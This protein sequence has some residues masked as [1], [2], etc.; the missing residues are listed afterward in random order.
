MIMMRIII[1][2]FSLFIFCCLY[3][4]SSTEFPN[5]FI[6]NTERVSIE[7]F[8]SEQN[9]FMVLDS[10][11]NHVISQA[12]QAIS[13]KDAPSY[14]CAYSGRIKYFNTGNELDASFNLS[15]DCNHIVFMN[16]DNLVAKKLTE[17]GR[18][19][20]LNL[21]EKGKNSTEESPIIFQFYGEALPTNLI[22]RDSI[23]LAYGFRMERVTGCVIDAKKKKEVDDHN[24]EA[25][26]QMVERH[27]KSWRY[28]F[29]E[30]TGFSLSPYVLY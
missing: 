19:F 14:K 27:G 30:T 23:S 2:F 24:T 20:L 3:A 15:E 6:N 28:D 26:L 16:G 13:S 1:C 10:K 29:E 11:D 21:M 25:A 7:L 17:K 9:S 12:I 18:I 8:D 4:C 5:E 22:I